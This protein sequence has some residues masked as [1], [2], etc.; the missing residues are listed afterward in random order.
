MISFF[1]FGGGGGHVSDSIFGWGAQ[2]TFILTLCNSK[3][4]WGA[5]AS[6][7]LLL[8]SP[9]CPLGD[10]EASKLIET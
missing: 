3:N 6:P 2:D 10:V 7:N 5:R 8:G 1:F 9:C 4:N